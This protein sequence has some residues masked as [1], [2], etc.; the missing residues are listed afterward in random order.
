[1][2]LPWLVLYGCL[3]LLAGLL[4]CEILMIFHDIFCEDRSESGNSQLD[5]E[6]IWLYKFTFT[7][8]YI[9]MH[10]WN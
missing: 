7:L 10:T 3:L 5:Y 8:I 2:L 9:A 1:M 6:L 4:M